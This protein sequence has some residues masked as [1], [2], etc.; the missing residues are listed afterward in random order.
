MSNSSELRDS[1]SP[2]DAYPTNDHPLTP[3]DATSQHVFDI[4]PDESAGIQSNTTFNH[5]TSN[6]D[7]L[8]TVESRSVLAVDAILDER[9]RSDLSTPKQ[10]MDMIIVYERDDVDPNSFRASP[11]MDLKAPA[12]KGKKSVRF[13]WNDMNRATHQRSTAKVTQQTVSISFD[14]AVGTTCFFIDASDPR[15]GHRCTTMRAYDPEDCGYLVRFEGYGSKAG[16]EEYSHS[17][18]VM[19]DHFIE[20]QHLS[21][22]VPRPLSER[23]RMSPLRMPAIRVHDIE[24]KQS[25]QQTPGNKLQTARDIELQLMDT[26]KPDARLNSCCQI[27]IK[28]LCPML[29]ITCLVSTDGLLLMAYFLDSE[30]EC[31]HHQS[32][33]D[34]PNMVLWIMVAFAVEVIQGL[35]L[36]LYILSFYRESLKS[37]VLPAGILSLGLTLICVVMGI[38]NNARWNGEDAYCQQSMSGQGMAIWSYARLFVVLC[39]GFVVVAGSYLNT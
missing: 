4:G 29:I 37:R 38:V 14:L 13:L 36:I 32:N 3:Y 23:D 21:L 35:V 15:Y 7:Q 31:L 5:R 12:M 16:D 33:S 22:S 9:A 20:I 18:H 26:I 10:E 25:P 34:G 11:P 30:D 17:T 27:T 6:C 28:Y 19:D 1:N 24:S 39:C 8:Q 2:V